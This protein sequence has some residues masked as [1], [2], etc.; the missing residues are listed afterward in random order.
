MPCFNLDILLMTFLSIDICPN[1]SN[2]SDYALTG[3]YLLA[4]YS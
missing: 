2:V 4:S 1:I 3:V